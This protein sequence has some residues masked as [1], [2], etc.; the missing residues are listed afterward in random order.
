MV[1]ATP[2][3]AWEAV[4]G[5]DP[6]RFYPGFSVVPAVRSV[7]VLSERWAHPGDRRRLWLARGSVSEQLVIVDSPTHL[8]YD[9]TEFTGFFG[10]S[11]HHAEARWTFVRSAEGTVIEW[12]YRFVPRRGWALV[13]RLLVGVVWAPYVARVLPA[14]A[15]AV[16]AVSA[17]PARRR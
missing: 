13:V 16:D 14:I 6:A 9:L 3:V 11:V 12:A 1:T 15:H 8:G 17:P 7:E 10:L 5:H 2:V 4:R